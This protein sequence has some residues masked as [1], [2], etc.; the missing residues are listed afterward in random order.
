MTKEEIK[1]LSDSIDKMSDR[2]AL[3]AIVRLLLE[4]L[5]DK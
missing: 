1:Q 4:L 3:R 2:D 5:K